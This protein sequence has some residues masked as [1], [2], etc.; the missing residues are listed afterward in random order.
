MQFRDED[1]SFDIVLCLIADML[2]LVLS[3]SIYAF[4]FA[5]KNVMPW[6]WWDRLVTFRSLLVSMAVTATQALLP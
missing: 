5:E 1:V 3:P 2:V 4:W 6:L